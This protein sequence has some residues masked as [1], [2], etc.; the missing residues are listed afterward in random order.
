MI[1][2][3]L[4]HYAEEL[5]A[6]LWFVPSLI[7]IGAVALAFGLIEAGAHLD[8]RVWEQLPHLF[9]AGAEGSRG[10]LAAIAGS[11]VTVA[12]VAFSVTVV[13][14][15]L[16]SSQY[17]SRV[18]RN[19]MGDRLN[20]AVLGV[21]VGIYAYCLVVLRTIRGGDEGAFVPPLAVLGGV[22]L[23]FVGI[24]CLIFFIHHIATAIQ[25]ANILA[26]V[27]TETTAAIDRLFPEGLGEPAAGDVEA[28]PAASGDDR[29]WHFLPARATGYIQGVNEDALLAFAREHQVVVRMES[30]IGAFVV[31]G[32]PLAAVSAALPAVDDA[33]EELNAAYT[34]GSQRTM[35]QDAAF[36]FRQIVD[37]AMK[38]LSPGVNDTTTAVMCIDRLTALLV[39]LASRRI[40]RPD[41]ME[42]G[43]LRIIAQGP[44]FAGLL[45]DSFDQIRQ[46]GGG[47]VAVLLRL[48]WALGL[49][50]GQVSPARRECLR[51]HA[52]AVA[53]VIDRTVPAPCDR[54]TLQ[55]QIDSLTNILAVDRL[56]KFETQ[57]ANGGPG[58]QTIRRESVNDHE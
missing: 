32:T 8:A 25:A 16:T 24:A 11:M 40:E 46:N 1:L 56:A 7:V 50:A 54:A 15:S 14:L 28:P 52:E 5:R 9:G 13:A 12:G 6:S 20:Q 21:F 49:L 10:M 34:V 30:G 31:R 33:I 29:A 37:V 41:R 58:H 44:T 23:A 45:A 19:F 47:N 3:K 35:G 2:H 42:D 39:Q 53:E 17:S 55:A 26:A 27:S 43:K 4:R 38:A 48:L 51:R 36:G 57:S 18:L 22:V